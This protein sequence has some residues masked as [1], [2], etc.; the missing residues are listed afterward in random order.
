MYCRVKCWAA[1][2][3]AS[4]VVTSVFA[5]SATAQSPPFSTGSTQGAIGGLPAASGGLQ[6]LVRATSAQLQIAYRHDAQEHQR[7]RDQVS[8]VVSAWQAATRSAANDELLADWLRVAIRRSMPGS[9]EALPAVPG[10]ERPLV[11][12]PRPA[13]SAAPAAQLR[14]RSTVR[15]KPVVEN[16][17]AMQAPT[18]RPADDQSLIRQPPESRTNATRDDATSPPSTNPGSTAG[19]AIQQDFWTTHPANVDVPT[20][21]TSGDPFG[22]DP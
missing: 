21:L 18:S 22:D 2:V 4:V 17:R 3:A 11:A 5:V 1:T 12:A 19:E 20:E 8:K 14:P 15:Q 10:F 13:T 7:R 9:R 16:Q 6:G